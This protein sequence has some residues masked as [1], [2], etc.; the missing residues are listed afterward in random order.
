MRGKSTDNK[1][2]GWKIVIEL[3]KDIPSAHTRCSSV[4]RCNIELIY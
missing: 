4:G 1:F 3:L 2:I